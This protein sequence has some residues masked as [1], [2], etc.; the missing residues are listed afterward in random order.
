MMD[1]SYT[2]HIVNRCFLYWNF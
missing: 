1:H 2:Y